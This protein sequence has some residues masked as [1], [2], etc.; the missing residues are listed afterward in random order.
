MPVGETPAPASP[1]HVSAL[2]QRAQAGPPS[3]PR[4][5]GQEQLAALLLRTHW[6]GRG[7]RGAVPPLS[8]ERCLPEF[9]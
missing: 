5:A 8:C 2:S 9:C 1:P 3:P 4:P 6:R 7:G